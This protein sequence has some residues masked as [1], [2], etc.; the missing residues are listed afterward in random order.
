MNPIQIDGQNLPGLFPWIPGIEDLS[1]MCH[2]KL[3]PCL[4]PDCSS[5][6]FMLNGWRSQVGS[7]FCI[8]QI[9]I[10][11]SACLRYGKTAAM[12]LTTYHR[13]RAS[14][15]NSEPPTMSAAWKSNTKKQ[16]GD[17]PMTRSRKHPETKGLGLQTS[18]MQEQV[19]QHCSSISVQLAWRRTL[20]CQANTR[21]IARQTREPL[22][23]SMQK[24]R[25]NFAALVLVDEVAELQLCPQCSVGTGELAML[26]ISWHILTS[27]FWYYFAKLHINHESWMYS[28]ILR[29]QRWPHG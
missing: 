8:L 11:A 7:G 5:A 25:E 10:R 22:P 19:S 24:D 29:L 1:E 12:L 23:L 20:P 26:N 14:R 3:W 9:Q 16:T 21:S 4:R 6:R 17:N 28:V 13:E 2:A 27:S 18:S 15:E